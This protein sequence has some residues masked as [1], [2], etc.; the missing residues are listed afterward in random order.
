M[1]MNFYF[2]NAL[3]VLWSLEKG[4]WNYSAGCW[5]PDL[6]AHGLYDGESHFP[7]APDVP[8]WGARKE[9]KNREAS[10]CQRRDLASCVYLVLVCLAS[11]A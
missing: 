7:P 4:W 10:L 3:P 9:S 11:S 2:P 5:S 6:L 1:E 8:S